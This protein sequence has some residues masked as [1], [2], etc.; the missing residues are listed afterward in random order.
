MSSAPLWKPHG[1][2]AAREGFLWGLHSLHHTFVVTY[3]SVTLKSTVWPRHS[4]GF[5]QHR[6]QQINLEL[7]TF[8]STALPANTSNSME[9]TRNTLVFYFKHSLTLSGMW[10]VWPRC[11]HPTA[12]HLQSMNYLS[13]PNAYV[14]RHVHKHSPHGIQTKN[15]CLSGPAGSSFKTDPL[16]VFLSSVYKLWY[17]LLQSPEL[18]S[19]IFHGLGGWGLGV[20][21]PT[22]ASSSFWL[23]KTP[24]C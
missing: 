15:S 14:R 8:T 24:R 5:L 13:V 6:H 10:L 16:F 12:K 20:A 21:E 9:M 1:S 23:R 18:Q 11:T 7:A 22:Y 19:G 17:L 2:Q 4:L 3:P